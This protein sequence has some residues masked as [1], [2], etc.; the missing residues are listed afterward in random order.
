[1]WCRCA[2]GGEPMASRNPNLSPSHSSSL[3]RGIRV[4][5]E[6]FLGLSSHGRAEQSRAACPEMLAN[7]GPPID[8]PGTECLLWV[9]VRRDPYW[10]G[11]GVASW[12]LSAVPHVG[13]SGA[14]C[15]IMWHRACFFLSSLRCCQAASSLFSTPQCNEYSPAGKHQVSP[16]TLTFL[17]KAAAVS[18]LHLGMSLR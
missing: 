8:Q 6:T 17:E 13:D 12:L 1:M 7:F 15:P 10:G 16:A 9:V 5:F 4:L 11:R 3:V 18:N 14:I 2:T